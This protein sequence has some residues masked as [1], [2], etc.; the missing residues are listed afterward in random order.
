M[1]TGTWLCAYCGMQPAP[2]TLGRAD[3]APID[4]GGAVTSAGAADHAADCPYFV[5]PT[6]A[7]SGYRGG[8][9]GYEP[10]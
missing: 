9:W 7:R 8:L 1:T 5:A 10:V 4:P 2:T 6:M 3:D